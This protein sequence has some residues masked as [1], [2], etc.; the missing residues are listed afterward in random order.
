MLR[1]WRVSASALLALLSISPVASARGHIIAG[2]GY[3]GGFY[4]PGWYSPGWYGGGWYGPHWGSRYGYGPYRESG[5]V[6]IVTETKGDPIYVDG[7]YAGLTGKLKK[8]P[9][10]PGAHTIELRDRTGH[11]YY[12]ERVE[13][14][15][16]RT[17][18]VRP[19]HQG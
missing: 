8:F 9:L 16:G 5:N 17:V 3:V 2:G 4:R 7:G 1:F 6:K 12:Q 10:R 11:A 19:A 13:V 14:I 18:E 15:L